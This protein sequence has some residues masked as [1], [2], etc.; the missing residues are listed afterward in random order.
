MKI[1]LEMIVSPHMT[2]ER[3]TVKRMTT[4]IENQFKE[5]IERVLFSS[6]TYQEFKKEEPNDTF[7][8]VLSSNFWLYWTKCL[9][10]TR[11]YEKFYND[12]R[13]LK[14]EEKANILKDYC[15]YFL[16]GS[17]KFEIKKEV[18]EDIE[19]ENG[20]KFDPTSNGRFEV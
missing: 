4:S 10:K 6:D 17:Q 3:V 2:N 14:G 11:A 12:A 20:Y 9:N 18:I 15:E 7:L 13:F 19:K 16:N 1:F 5:V 8:S